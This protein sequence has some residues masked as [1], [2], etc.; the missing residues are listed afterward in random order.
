[1]TSFQRWLL[2]H[3]SGGNIA[4][5]KG[6]RGGGNAVA[7]R[8]LGKRMAEAFAGWGHGRQWSDLDWIWTQESGWE[9]TAAYDKSNPYAHAYGIPQSNPGTKMASAGP[10][11][12]T[13]AATQIKWG[14]GYIKGTYGDPIRTAIH[15]HAVGTYA[16]GGFAKA[17]DGVSRFLG[18]IPG[19]AKG[20]RGPRRGSTDWRRQHPRG[21]SAPSTIKSVKQAMTP[22]LGKFNADW[23]LDGIAA[24]IKPIADEYDYE[25]RRYD[26]EIGVTD[27]IIPAETDSAGNITSPARLD[28]QALAEKAASLDKLV[29]YRQQI[30][31]LLEEARRQIAAMIKKLNE[32]IRR[33]Q[34]A[35]K[36]STGKDR[37]YG[38]L[39]SEYQD[40]IA[41]LGN[42]DKDVSK[43]LRDAKLDVTGITKERDALVPGAEKALKDA[44][45]TGTTTSASDAI[46]V[47]A[48]EQLTSFKGGLD[49]L[50]AEHGFNFQGRG[51]PGL[52]R[53]G[54]G[55]SPNEQDTVMMA[56]VR[57]FGGASGG[58]AP[59]ASQTA[60]GVVFQ[61]HIEY[62]EQPHDPHVHAQTSAFELRAALR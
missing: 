9:T 48:S 37:G 56:G 35:M 43:Q 62:R 21:D 20:R 25:T 4:A 54:G 39:I 13:D 36:S 17:R 49:S 47:A 29:G 30:V 7:N 19:A 52:G 15:K 57:H 16:R 41:G 42:L 10:K 50:F 12:R 26:T 45:G 59:V 34:N 58:L 53:L 24:K 51:L 27:F 33:L 18:S 60:G 31:A 32:A 38:K 6:F 40:E 44:L 1:M 11:W 22:M 3:S 23:G 2:G 8:K 55:L 5:L 14:L 28:E 46:A 61:Q